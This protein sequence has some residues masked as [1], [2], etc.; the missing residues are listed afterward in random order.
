MITYKTENTFKPFTVSFDIDTREE[1]I[2]LIN[3]ACALT[4]MSTPT[5]W[6]SRGPATIFQ[7]REISDKMV[8]GKQWVE[9]V[10]SVFGEK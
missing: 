2:A 1:A 5:P 10:D 6:D 9:L 7:M 3:A 8:S 4:N